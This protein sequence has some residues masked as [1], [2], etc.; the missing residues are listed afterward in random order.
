[1]VLICIIIIEDL[2]SIFKN[3]IV[4]IYYDILNQGFYNGI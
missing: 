1:M 4:F 2:G 3:K